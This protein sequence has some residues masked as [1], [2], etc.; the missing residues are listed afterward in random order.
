[1]LYTFNMMVRKAAKWAVAA[2]VLAVSTP[3][4]AQPKADLVGSYKDWFV[5]TAGTGANKVCYAL[6]Q[7]KQS[8]PA[9]VNRDP[10][11]FMVSTWPTKKKGGEPSVVPG[12]EYKNGS[13]VQVQIGA[14]T[15]NF[16]TENEGK[17]GSAWTKNP[18]DERRI[19]AAMKKGSNMSITGTSARGT[20]T[21]DTYS[22]AGISAALDKV[23]ATCK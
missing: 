10:T 3:A 22:L 5:Y 6:S 15:F 19:L 16:F 9:G 17:D 20:L 23:A 18:A 8:E 12:Y 13:Q 11:F 1:M 14:D 2:A 7:P 4:L 21:Q